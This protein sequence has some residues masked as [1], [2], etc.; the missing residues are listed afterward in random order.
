M[1]LWS[2]HLGVYHQIRKVTH[3]LFMNKQVSWLSTHMIINE[4]GCY[5]VKIE[6]VAW[7]RL[8]VTA[9]FFTFLYFRL[10][11]SKFIYFQCEA[12]CSQ[13]WVH[14]NVRKV[15]SANLVHCNYAYTQGS[16][17]HTIVY[18]HM[19]HKKKLISSLKTIYTL[20]MQQN[21]WFWFYFSGGPEWWKIRSW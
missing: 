14:M 17:K 9:S 12:R 13:H 2:D 6:E 4:F 15:H 5:E 11:T 21:R 20:I 18:V 7:V 8:P 19:H 1:S 3:V 10:I 16:L